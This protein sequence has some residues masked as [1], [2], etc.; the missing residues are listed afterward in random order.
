MTELASDKPLLPAAAAAVASSIAFAPESVTAQPSAASVVADVIPA[1]RAPAEPMVSTAASVGPE[2]LAPVASAIQPESTTDERVREE[3]SPPDVVQPV[4]HD[5]TAPAPLQL[6]WSSDLI[7][8]ETHPEKA[9]IALDGT[10]EEA[11]APRVKRERPPPPL[12]V[13]PLVQVET[14][15]NEVAVDPVVVVQNAGGGEPLST[16]TG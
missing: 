1:A 12:G 14:R 9:R 16:T 4:T 15:R 8:V 10:R 13:E 5:K 7:Q 2:T 11:P 3:I 6:D